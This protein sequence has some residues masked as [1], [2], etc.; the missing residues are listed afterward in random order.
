MSGSIP[1]ARDD[2]AL[3]MGLRF[4][5]R[6]IAGAHRFLHEAV[7]FGDLGQLAVAHHVQTGVAHVDPGDRLGAVHRR[8]RHQRGA[9][10]PEVGITGRAR[11]HGVVCRLRGLEQSVRGGLDERLVQRAQ[12]S[13]AGDLAALMAAHAVRDR[14]QSFRREHGVF[15]VRAYP[16]DV[17]RFAPAQLDHD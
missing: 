13:V 10:A 12:R 8:D 17:C 2:V 7:V 14:E 11:E 15:V 16:T 1:N 6:E 9:H 4:L 5:R 3:R